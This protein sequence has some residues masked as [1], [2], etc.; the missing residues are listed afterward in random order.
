MKNKLESILAIAG[1]AMLLA[2]LIFIP[3][4]LLGIF[5]KDE[6]V[7]NYQVGMVYLKKMHWKD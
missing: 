7:I 4:K 3:S 2:L 1:L 5:G 6:S